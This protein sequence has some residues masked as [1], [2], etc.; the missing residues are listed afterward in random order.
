MIIIITT[1]TT[2]TTTIS[3]IKINITSMIMII[4]RLARQAGVQAGR[5]A[6]GRKASI[7]DTQ[8]MYGLILHIL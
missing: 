8:Y 6:G 1:T 4:R 7:L 2:T 3:I 5:W